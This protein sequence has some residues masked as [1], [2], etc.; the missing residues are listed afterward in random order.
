[1][2]IIRKFVPKERYNVVDRHVFTRRDLSYPAKSLYGYLAGLRSGANFSDEYLMK[3]MDMSKNTLA[4]RKKELKD[5][6]LILVE[7]IKPRVFAIYIGTSEYPANSVKA[8]WAS[9]EEDKE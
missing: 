1:M 6:G 9:M 3:A 5:A 2:A 4:R 7:Q 8:H